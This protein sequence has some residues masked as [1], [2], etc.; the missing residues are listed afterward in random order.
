[1]A[2]ALWAANSV[3]ALSWF[4]KGKAKDR[5]AKEKQGNGHQFTAGPGQGSSVCEVCDK[6]AAGKDTLHCTSE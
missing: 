2:V 1:M 6:P 5:E 4:S 3:M